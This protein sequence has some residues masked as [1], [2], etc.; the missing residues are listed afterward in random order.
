MHFNNVFA[1][2]LLTVLALTVVLNGAVWGSSYRDSKS[3]AWTSVSQMIK[4]IGMGDQPS[5]ERAGNDAIGS[6]EKAIDLE[7][8]SGKKD[9]LRDA[10]TRVREALSHAARGEWPNAES[11]AKRALQLIED[12][13]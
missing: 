9:K 1:R 7:E 8:D 11:S 6:L 2:S 4:F 12:V 5:V 3:D 10:K 13:K